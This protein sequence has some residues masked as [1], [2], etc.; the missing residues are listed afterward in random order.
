M[1]ANETCG[2][3]HEYVSQVFGKHPLIFSQGVRLQCF[4]GCNEL[5]DLL[6][7]HHMR[8]EGS[9]ISIPSCWDTAG[10]RA[11]LRRVIL[12]SKLFKLHLEWLRLMEFSS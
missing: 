3:Y 4:M 8:V 2:T 5:A 6:L 7:K 1:F 10:E 12:A 11:T 9:E